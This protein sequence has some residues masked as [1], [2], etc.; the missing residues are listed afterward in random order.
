[1][2]QLK[3]AR[4]AAPETI[5]NTDTGKPELS[6]A[7]RGR[8]HFSGRVFS[9]KVDGKGFGRF[10]RPFDSSRLLMCL[11]SW[12]RFA[13]HPNQAPANDGGRGN[14]ARAPACFPL[15]MEEIFRGK[16]DLMYK[17]A[18]LRFPASLKRSC[19]ARSNKRHLKPSQSKKRLLSRLA[20][21]RATNPHA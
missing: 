14:H 2:R 11:L 18:R 10:L 19:C 15:F 9:V 20:H 17:Q 16:P 5:Y 7:F 21:S 6:Y 4:A 8:V 13:L 3:P 12:P 1:M